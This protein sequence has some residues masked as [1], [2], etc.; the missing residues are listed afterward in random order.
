[1]H[2]LRSSLMLLLTVSTATTVACQSADTTWTDPFEPVRIADNLYY[3]GT[4]GLSAFLLTSAAG[5]IRI[6]APMQENVPLI[7]ENIRSVG[8]D[9]HDVRVHLATHAHYDHVGGFSDMLQVT[10]GDLVISERDASFVEAGA[11]FGFDDEAA[12]NFGLYVDGYPSAVVTR[13]FAR[14]M[15]GYPP[16]EVTRTIAHLEEVRVG[17]LAL[18]A[19]VTPGHTPGCTSWSGSVRIGDERLQFV[20]VCSLTVLSM[21]R[22]AGDEPTYEGQASDFCRSLAY[23]RTLEPDIFLSNHAQGFNL[24][25]KSDALRA[26]DPRAFVDDTNYHRFLDGAEIAI[27]K[28]LKDQGLESCGALLR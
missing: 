12:A 15:A 8:F 24:R 26:G 6:D 27:E 7:L 4:A 28:A 9:P 25:K 5:H 2:R 1:M 20:L 19:H 18:T 21:Y 10:G 14:L 3:V 13:A 22:L 23:L 16:A 11:D 17:D